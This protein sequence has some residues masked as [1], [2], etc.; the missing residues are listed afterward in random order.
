MVQKAQQ[1]PTGP[2]LF[3]L[4]LTHP[5]LVTPGQLL[6]RFAWDASASGS[7]HRLPVPFPPA[8]HRIHCLFS[9]PSPSHRLASPGLGKT[10]SPALLSLPLSACCQPNVELSATA[11]GSAYPLLDSSRKKGCLFYHRMCEVP[12]QPIADSMYSMN[13]Y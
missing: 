2:T 10:P 11:T 9:F 12:R 3:P 4:P 6:L 1:D 5:T 13:S 8:F 7:L